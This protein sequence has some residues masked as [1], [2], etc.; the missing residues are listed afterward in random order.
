M[1]RCA[2]MVN[3]AIVINGRRLWLPRSRL[4]FCHVANRSIDASFTGPMLRRV[5]AIGIE[6]E[7]QLT[8]E[9]TPQN[10]PQGTLLGQG[11]PPRKPLHRHRRGWGYVV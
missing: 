4:G 3:R 7:N 10:H 5:A 1:I 8:P 11:C 9:L 2:D 6:F